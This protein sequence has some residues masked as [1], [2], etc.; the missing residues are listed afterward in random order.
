MKNKELYKSIDE[1]DEAFKQY[2]SEA[3]DFCEGRGCLKCVL[4][5]LEAEVD[6]D[7]TDT[8]E[9]DPETSVAASAASDT[10]QHTKATQN[11]TR[12]F[13]Q[14]QI[15]DKKV[16]QHPDGR[17]SIFFSEGTSLHTIY[18]KSDNLHRSI[19]ARQTKKPVEIAHDSLYE[20]VYWEEV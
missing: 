8:E 3:V 20:W 19:L 16:R 6:C 4:A 15:K 18:L 13:R 2:C 1:Q 5:W 14:V 17:I 7:S 11:I 9:D 12:L 10:Q